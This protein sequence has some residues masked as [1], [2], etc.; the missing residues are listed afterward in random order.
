LKTLFYNTKDFEQSFLDAAKDRQRDIVLIKEALSIQTAGKAKGFGIIS[1]SAGDIASSDVLEEL[2]NY[3]VKYIAIRAAV[4]DNIDVAKAMAL[5]LKL[6]YVPDF[7]P[8]PI[9][10]H[11]TALVLAL[12]RKICIADKQV[13]DQNFTVSN[14]VG[15]DLHGKTVGI[16]GVGKTGGAFVKIMHGFGCRLLG[17]D[18]R[19]NIMLHEKYGLE[20]VDLPALCR[21]ANIISIHT[22]LTP[23]TKYLINKKLISLMQHGVMI[24]NT[25]HGECVNTADIIEGLEN[26]HIGYYG[27]DVYEKE[28]GIFCYDHLGKELKDKI[29]KKLLSLPNVLITPHQGFA[30]R[31]T[32]ANIAATT[33][34]TLD[35]WKKD[36]PSANE[37][38]TSTNL[39]GSAVFT[40]YES[41]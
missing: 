38:T 40:D 20:W 33:F 26:G 9:A 29:L 25:S 22:S 41:L 27:S 8:Y 3:G 28:K 31:D 39:T 1:L 2:H 37:L 17:Y 6:A 21:E 32:L 7:S 16:I 24:I 15:F 23:H 11:A 14:L 34:Y 36:Q 4:Y 13:H 30:T 19:E 10:E 12:N 35:C 18:I 5:G